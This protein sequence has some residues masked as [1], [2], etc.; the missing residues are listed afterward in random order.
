MQCRGDWSL[1]PPS[2]QSALRFQY[3][4]KRV[5]EIVYDV[6]LRGLLKDRSPE[7]DTK[8]LGV[9]VDEARREEVWAALAG[10]QTG[11]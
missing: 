10:T 11:R 8:G 1:T 3:D 6:S 7:W 9:I 2:P 5:E 4:V